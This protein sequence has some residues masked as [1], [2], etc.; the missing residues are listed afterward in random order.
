MRLCAGRA[1]TLAKTRGE[2][3]SANL[4]AAEMLLAGNELAL[5]EGVARV[6]S[7]ITN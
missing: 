6:R 4:Y 7:L 2:T 1:L 3:V 5:A